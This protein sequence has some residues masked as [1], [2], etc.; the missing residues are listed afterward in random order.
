MWAGRQRAW[1]AGLQS[2]KMRKSWDGC[3]T[4][5][6]RPQRQALKSVKVV[7]FLYTLPHLK[8]ITTTARLLER[9]TS[10][11]QQMSGLRHPPAGVATAGESAWAL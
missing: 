5:C 9:F 3:T 1:G 4:V 2:G 8:K 7:S 11:C 6:L 10:E